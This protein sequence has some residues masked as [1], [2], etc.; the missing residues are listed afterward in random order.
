M[1]PIPT[2]ANP[3]RLSECYGH[4]D[5]WLRIGSALND[6]SRTWAIPLTSRY[7]ALLSPIYLGAGASLGG[8]G[9][10]SLFLAALQSVHRSPPA[11]WSLRA[12]LQLPLG[13]QM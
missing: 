9:S 12:V 13:M 8:G 7:R 11:F 1:R 10:S 6:P 2:V 4:R 5:A 3:C